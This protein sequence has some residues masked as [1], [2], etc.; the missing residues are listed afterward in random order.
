MLLKNF[1]ALTLLQISVIDRMNGPMYTLPDAQYIHRECALLLD[2][3]E[4]F[5]AEDLPKIKKLCKD[6]DKGDITGDSW[7]ESVD[8]FIRYFES[9]AARCSGP[10]CGGASALPLEPH[11]PIP[12]NFQTYSLFLVPTLSLGKDAKKDDLD[13]I[14]ALKAAFQS[15]GTAIGDRKAAIWLLDALPNATVRRKAP[16]DSTDSLEAAEGIDT[17]RSKYYC[18]KL[19]LNYNDGPYVVTT[20]IRPDHLSSTDEKV[21]IKLGGISADR[22]IA[23]L[24]ILEQ[25]LRLEQQIRKRTLLF[26]EIEQRMLTLTSRYPDALKGVLSFLTKS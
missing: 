20:R 17:L 11:R 19:G 4:E 9:L 6:A 13:A 26:E 1:L 24:N 5:H 16:K 18:D 23:V 22:L 10:H 21:I 2:Q 25:D 7:L 3:A 8:Y 14:F 12:D 15:F